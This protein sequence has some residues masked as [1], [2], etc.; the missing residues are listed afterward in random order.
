LPDGRLI[1]R[2]TTKWKRF[3]IIFARR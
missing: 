3:S 2:Q 1:N